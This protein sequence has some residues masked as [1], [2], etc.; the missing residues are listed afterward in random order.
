MWQGMS[1]LHLGANWTQVPALI[2]R[3]FKSCLTF[4]PRLFLIAQFNPQSKKILAAT[5][6]VWAAMIG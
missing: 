5:P 4:L 1:T 3:V 2:G 6:K